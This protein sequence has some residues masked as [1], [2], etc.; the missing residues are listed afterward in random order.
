MAEY[1]G[2]ISRTR[3]KMAERGIDTLLVTNPVSTNYLSGYVTFGLLAFQ[4]LILPSD[5]KPTMLTFELELPGVFLSSWIED[6]VSYKAGQDPYQATRALLEER[7]LL[8]GTVG[9]ERD[10]LFFPVQ[11]FER[12]VTAFDGVKLGDGSGIV[13][14]L[15][16]VKSPAEVEVIRQ[17]GV[18]TAKGMQA[19]I[20]AIEPGVT[21]NHVAAAAYE[22]LISAGSE[23]MALDPVVTTGTRSGVPHT[24]HRRITI[25]QGDPVWIE[26]GACFQRYSAP[27]MRTVF[28][29]K[30][31]D[32]VQK[33]AD[34]SLAALNAVLT[35][36]KPGM[37][38]EDV[39]AQ[40]SRVLPLD[41]PTVVFHHT[42][43][44]SIG[45]GYPPDW[46]D[47]V[48][49]RLRKGTKD[50]LVPGMVFHVTMGLRRDS[51]YGAV[52]SETAV[53]TE[54]GMEALTSFPRQYF[55]K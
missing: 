24:T 55:Y 38:A 1:E 47:D 17:A 39:A 12:Y 31:T 14:S 9:I 41:D 33:L 27:L 19:A 40:V 23:F 21:D 42:Y 53:I 35:T 10:S 51:Q 11:A 30:P 54:T 43:G 28:V 20:D 4:C 7:G 46:S 37:V 5:G 26:V 45:L 36:A 25:K 34:A 8:K 15:M 29:G 3:A 16:R 2:R 52:T 22:A 48:P 50:V 6:G 32:E 13:K 44:Y 49:L 18:M